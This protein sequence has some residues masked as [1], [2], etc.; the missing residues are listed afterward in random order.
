VATSLNDIFGAPEAIQL[1]ALEELR[2]AGWEG[3]QR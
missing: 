2:K 3:L 1:R